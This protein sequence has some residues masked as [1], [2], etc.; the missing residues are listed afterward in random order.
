MMNLDISRLISMHLL[1]LKHFFFCCYHFKYIFQAIY[2]LHEPKVRIQKTI[3]AIS[4]KKSIIKILKIGILLLLI[5][6]QKP[7]HD[8]PIL[9]KVIPMDFNYF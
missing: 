1:K 8:D 6:H 2:I 7:N 5:G 4:T 3:L 9:I